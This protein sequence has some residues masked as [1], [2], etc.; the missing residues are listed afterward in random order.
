M[1]KVPTFSGS[2]FPL[3]LVVATPGAYVA[4][5]PLDIKRGIFFH[6]QCDWGDISKPEKEANDRAVDEG[7][8]VR[9]GHVAENG[10][11]FLVITEA[12][13]ST[14]TVLLPDED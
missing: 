9:S 7:G 10:T 6:S 14:T 5:T 8:P 3:G 13:R 11:R 2:Q 4:L 1:R 12:D